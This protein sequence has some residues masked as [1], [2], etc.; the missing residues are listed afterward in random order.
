MKS[1]KKF[2]KEQYETTKIQNVKAVFDIF[3]EEFYLNAPENYS[4]SDLQIYLCD[5]LLKELPADNND[6]FK[7]LIGKNYDN[8]NDAY[9]E[10]DKFEHLNEDIQ[11]YSLKWDPYYDEKNK[12]ELN[13][14]KL[15]KLKY[16]I[17][18]DEFEILSEGDIKETLNNIFAQLDSSRINKYPVDIKYNPDKLEYSE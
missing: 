16:I 1:L 17:L 8:I 11:E 13:T 5:V 12:S 15:T 10:Y 7:K 2:I 14:F 6:K 4:E 3:P 18:F 9:F